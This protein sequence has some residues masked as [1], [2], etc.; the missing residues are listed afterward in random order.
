MSQGNLGDLLRNVTKMRKDIDK[1]Q[2]SLKGRF[3]EARAGGDR[4][5]VTL[6]G[7]QELMKIQIDP[8]LLAPGS[9]G[10]PD[11]ALLEDLIVAALSQGMEKSK[12]LMRT[13]MEK[14]TGDLGLGGMFPGMFG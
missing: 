8:G 1:V 4:V 6:N 11:V 7:R 13:E 12:T 2:E 10:K 5:Q 14:V 3:V 9:D